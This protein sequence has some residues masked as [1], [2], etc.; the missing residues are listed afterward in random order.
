MSSLHLS[1]LHMYPEFFGFQLLV[2]E[3]ANYMRMLSRV[4][5]RRNCEQYDARCYTHLCTS[6]E[7]LLV[8]FG[9]KATLIQ[10]LQPIFVNFQLPR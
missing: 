10:L 8:V 4:G 1:L 9:L 2:P 6:M 7:F 5:H 3:E